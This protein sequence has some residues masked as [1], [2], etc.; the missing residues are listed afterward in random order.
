MKIEVILS[1]AGFFLAI[2]GFNIANSI[3]AFIKNRID[4]VKELNSIR[5]RCKEDTQKLEN[6]A[7]T[8]INKTIAAIKKLSSQQQNMIEKHNE[9]AETVFQIQN[10]LETHHEFQIKKKSPDTIGNI[11]PFD[12]LEL[13]FSITEQGDLTK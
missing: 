5:D 12:S 7:R 4:L 6:L 1:I 8:K 11:N 2:S 10:F 3:N 9:I 13:D